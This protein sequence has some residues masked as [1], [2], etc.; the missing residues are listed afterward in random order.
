MRITEAARAAAKRMA[1]RKI[2]SL[3]EHVVEVDDL[4]VPVLSPDA[5]DVCTNPY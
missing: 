5:P 3:Y 4:G 1:R 2:R